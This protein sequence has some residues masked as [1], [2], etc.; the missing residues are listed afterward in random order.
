M[1][2]QP[3]HQAHWWQLANR[4][5]LEKILSEFSYEG[6]VSPQSQP[7]GDG[8]LR[9]QLPPEAGGWHWLGHTNLWGQSIVQPGSVRDADGQPA[10]DALTLLRSVLVPLQLDAVTLANYLHETQQTLDADARLL[11]ARDGLCAAD[12]LA[13]PDDAVQALLDGHPKAIPSKGRLGWSARDSQRYAPEQPAGFRLRWLAVSTT[14]ARPVYAAGWDAARLLAHTCDAADAARLQA[15]LDSLPGH[16]SLLPVH[17]WQWQ[18]R[19]ASQ[20]AAL[21]A[22]G[23]LVDLGDGQALYRAQPSLRSLYH[24]TQPKAANLK[25]PLS[26]LNTSAYRG[27]P[28]TYLAM[29][30]ALS[31]SLQQLLATDPLLAACGCR[32]LAEPAALF[33]PHPVYHGLS[34]VPYQLDEMLGAVWRDSPASQCAPGE[35]VLMAAVLQ[36]H[37]D[38]GQL[39]SAVMIQRSGLSGEAWLTRLF[40]A[41]VIPLYH[42]QARYGLGFIAHGQ[43]LMLRFAGDVPV[44]MVLKDYQ[45]DVFR[46]EQGWGAPPGMA[47]SLWQALPAMPPHYLLHNLWTGLFAS[48]FRFLASSLHQAGLV[49][50]RAFYRLLR[51][52]LHAYQ[53]A[54]PALTQQFAALDLF[55]AEMPRLSLN[56]AR[57]AA[58]YADSASRPIHA[59]G[60]A[61]ANPLCQP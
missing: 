40:D 45:G 30:P 1:S 50:E 35:R 11:A 57:F 60:P 53:Q 4:R 46:A 6:L 3:S 23:Q 54:H 39:L 47:D 52:R 16:Y 61:I 59:L 19:I 33:V 58:G 36:Q 8:L 49:D 42:L 41:A 56:R 2:V 22:N 9:Y 44:G 7:V 37:D 32:A 25:L 15:S 51:Q 43:N 26:I 28:A 55:K 17:P 29:T 38:R 31:D 20:Y 5:L 18:H 13:Q 21:F 34:G 24:T 27:L 10:G 12:W 14:L 48:V